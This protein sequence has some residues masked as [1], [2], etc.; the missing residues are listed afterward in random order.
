MNAYYFLFFR[1]VNRFL[2]KPLVLVSRT[3]FA[4]SGILV[5]I[6]LYLDRVRLTEKHD[7]NKTTRNIS[8]I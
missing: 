4:D 3:I 5:S 8:G 2:S 1:I 7:I 6:Y